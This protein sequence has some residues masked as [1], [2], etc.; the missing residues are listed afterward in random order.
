MK[1]QTTILLSVLS[2][3]TLSF[4]QGDYDQLYRRDAMA[5]AD[6]Y[7]YAD[8][9]AFAYAA[10]DPY[11]DA[12]AFLDDYTSFIQQRDAKKKQEDSWTPKIVG[13]YKKDTLKCN[14]KHVCSGEIVV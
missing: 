7:A 2:L 14:S 9:E 10:A 4:A 3:S 8:P 13:S 11:A 1:F 6:P 5:E 12:S